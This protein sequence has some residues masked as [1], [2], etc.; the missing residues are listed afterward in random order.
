MNLLINALITYLRAESE[1]SA[2][3]GTRV[4][5]DFI[6]NAGLKNSGLSSIVLDIQGG[7]VYNGGSG[8][9]YH[10]IGVYCYSD[11]TR[12][13]GIASKDDGS[14]RA[15]QLYHVLNNKMIFNER[16]SLASGDILIN[17][18][19]KYNEPVGR[20][21]KDLEL[22]FVYST[23]EMGVIYDLYK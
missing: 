5:K 11:H 13:D 3:V 20:W 15:W 10:M 7:P 9:H 23:Y 6:K 2:L 14:D 19:I 8:I 12:V 22:W 21:D 16:M 18:S 17:K 4:E 1:I